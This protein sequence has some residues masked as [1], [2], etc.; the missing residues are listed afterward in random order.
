MTD[1]TVE[2]LLADPTLVEARSWLD[3]EDGAERTLGTLR[4]AEADALVQRLYTAG[5]KTVFVSRVEAYV[6]TEDGE[7]F[8]FEDAHAL[9]VELPTDRDARRRLFERHAEN[10]QDY[11]MVPAFDAGQRHLQFRVE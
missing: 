9:V 11:A 2:S 1:T 7:A 5:A 3:R 10:A 8:A 4:A 6:L